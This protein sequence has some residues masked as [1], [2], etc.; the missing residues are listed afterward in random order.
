MAS[1]ILD[2]LEVYVHDCCSEMEWVVFALEN[3]LVGPNSA[4][5][6]NDLLGSY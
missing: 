1:M 6:Q 5:Y 4:D 3:Y 2:N